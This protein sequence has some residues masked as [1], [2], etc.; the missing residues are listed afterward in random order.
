MT[1]G[2]KEYDDYEFTLGNELEQLAKDELRETKQ[3]RDHAIKMLREWIE[4]NPRIV[5]ARTGKNRLLY[6][7][8][9]LY[10]KFRYLF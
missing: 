4:T 2:F 7:V 8:H 3:T 6:I 1:K 5:K 9:N 10:S